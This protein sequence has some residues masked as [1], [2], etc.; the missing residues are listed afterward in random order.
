MTTAP[1]DSTSKTDLSDNWGSMVPLLPGTEG[2]QLY[3]PDASFTSTDARSVN[4]MYCNLIFHGNR[5]FLSVCYGDGSV[6]YHSEGSG[7]SRTSIYISS[8]VSL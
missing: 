2:K 4:G 6:P 3:Q 8:S 1:N 5:I 7:K